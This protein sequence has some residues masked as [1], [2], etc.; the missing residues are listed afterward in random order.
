LR[1]CPPPGQLVLLA[2]NMTA[3]SREHDCMF[4][5]HRRT[6]IAHLRP[7]SQILSRQGGLAD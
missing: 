6:A 7:M 3:Y 5:K 2:R 1:I 4:P